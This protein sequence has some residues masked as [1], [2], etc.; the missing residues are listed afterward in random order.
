M[1]SLQHIQH[2]KIQVFSIS[3]FT[4]DYKKTIKFNSEEE[5]RKFFEDKNNTLLKEI[6]SNNNFSFTDKHS[7][8]TIEGELSKYENA[9]Y[10][11]FKNN[12]RWFYGFVMDTVYLNKNTTR[13]IYE[14][15][16]FQTYHIELFKNKIK[17]FVQTAHQ[18]RKINDKLNI[19]NSL[20]GFNVGEKYPYK[21]HTV[22]FPIKWVV[23]VMK[24]STK[25]G[26]KDIYGGYIL[27]IG[28]LKNFKYYILP[29]IKKGGHAFIPSIEY[30]GKT[31][32][33]MEFQG[34]FKEVTNTF[35]LESGQNTVN[36][37]VNVY[38]T[39]DCGIDYEYYPETETVKINKKDN[40]F[41]EIVTV[42]SPSNQSTTTKP[43]G[44]NGFG[45]LG[46]FDGDLFYSGHVLKKSV[47]NQIIAGC[48]QYKIIPQG[49]ICQ[50]YLESFW[51]ASN[52]AKI[53]N[54][55]GGITY[56][57]GGLPSVEKTKGSPR[58]SNEGGNYVHWN[59][60]EDY[61]KDYLYLLRPN[62]LYAVSEQ[63]TILDYTKGLFIAGGKGSKAD[64]AASGL[65]HYITLM[66]DIDKGIIKE[67]GTD[68]IT[69]INEQVYKGGKWL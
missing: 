32:G 6:Y 28:S 38:I 23:F 22:E 65:N 44:N 19:I 51:G 54:N 24:P 52:V 33:R 9:T 13:I 69:K 61:I 68:K 48:R 55:W 3:P 8:I 25:I 35:N 29:F 46:K 59:S 62:N 39:N 58:P 26:E 49:V 53:D 10:L 27:N 45:E 34:I 42:G 5:Q 36:Q 60:P 16:V 18:K 47:I 1:D 20:Q 37:A 15:D 57:Y 2:T 17:G 41:L 31:Q 64:Y 7:D 43:D 40:V 14:I 56:P 12:G 63:I 21:T 66:T 67:N 30:D 50:L 11:C 4:N